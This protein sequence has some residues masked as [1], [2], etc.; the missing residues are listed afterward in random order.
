MLTPR[1][2]FQPG[3]QYRRQTTT[4]DDPITGEIIA[5][6]YEPIAGTGIVQEAYWTGMQETTPT[7]GIRDER[8]VMFAPAGVTV[9]D[10][11]VTAKDEFAGPDGRVWQC[12]SDGIARGIPGR[13]PDYIAA[14]VRRAKEKEQP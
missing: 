9:D 14:R 4:R 1:V 8:L 10:L 2:L 6:T 5:T 12:I 3:W 13:P 11:D 7:G